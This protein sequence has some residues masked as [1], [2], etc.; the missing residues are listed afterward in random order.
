MSTSAQHP[1][2][3]LPGYALDALEE[4]ERS[5]VETHVAGCAECRAEVA[6]LIAAADALAE[7]V[8]P[9]A[10]PPA[11]RERLMARIAADR[12]ASGAASAGTTVAVAEP[13]I[14]PP[15]ATPPPRVS[16]ATG[17]RVG[18]GTLAAGLVGAGAIALAAFS[19]WQAVSAQRELASVQTGVEQLRAQ[20]RD[21]TGAL[22][23]L[24]P[25]GQPAGSAPRV[26][27]LQWSGGAAAAVSGQLVYQP[28]GRAAIA[29]IERLPPL[30]PGY[31][32]QLWW[33][34]GNT[35]TPAA[36]FTPDE[37][38]RGSVVLRAPERLDSYSVVA[39]TAEPAPGRATPTGP[40]LA[41]AALIPT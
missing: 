35:P 27:P 39:L 15:R 37:T 30:Q 12:V 8:A 11:A 24:N 31:V 4:D 18:A 7:S 29:L 16:R 26:A 14:D 28:T 38:G 2:A 41:S 20:L 17:G 23:E 32:Y 34:R 1:A 22:A 10:P 21:L 5:A 25:A 9:V 33:V 6:R 36:T 13:I 40:I 19:T 3:L